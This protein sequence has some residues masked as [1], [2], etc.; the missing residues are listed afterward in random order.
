MRLINSLEKEMLQ[1][2]W[3]NWLFDENDTCEELIE[4]TS[5]M[6]DD[7]S[8]R[9]HNLSSSGKQLDSW[10]TGYCNSCAAEKERTMKSYEVN[11]LA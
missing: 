3:E 5:G 2:E 10:F 6:D 11:G 9:S 7:I 4:L 1:A 8:A